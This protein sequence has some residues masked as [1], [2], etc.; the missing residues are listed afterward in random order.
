MLDL[1]ETSIEDIVFDED[2]A[3]GSP[4]FGEDCTE[5]NLDLCLA[6]VMEAE[7]A[8]P[9]ARMASGARGGAP[10]PTVSARPPRRWASD[11]SR[12]ASDL[13][14][15]ND[16][17]PVLAPEFLVELP[18]PTPLV[19]IELVAPRR[20]TLEGVRIVLGQPEI[21][22]PPRKRSVWLRASAAVLFA[23]SIP[24]AWA[25][26]SRLASASELLAFDLGV[27]VGF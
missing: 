5:V 15:A 23:A 3:V 9:I 2:A 12:L 13:L 8:E 21:V 1:L 20:E 19:R 7:L 27:V 10:Q 25:L 16:D 6:S 18:A 14:P 4:D 24:A 22:L 11:V 26:V 17:L